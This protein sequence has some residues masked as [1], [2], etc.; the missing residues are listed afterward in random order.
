M[1]KNLPNTLQSDAFEQGNLPIRDLF[2]DA[3]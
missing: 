1:P 2:G 3:G